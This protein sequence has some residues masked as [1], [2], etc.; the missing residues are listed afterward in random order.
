MYWSNLTFAIFSFFYTFLF[1]N[2]TVRLFTSVPS[3]RTEVGVYI[4]TMKTIF[5]F[6]F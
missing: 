3:F 2:F 5:L 1:G 6:K 4:N